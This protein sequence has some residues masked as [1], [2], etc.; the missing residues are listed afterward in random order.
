MLEICR[1]KGLDA[2]QFSCYKCKVPIGVNGQEARLCDYSG[3][4]YCKLCHL[5]QTAVIPARVLHSWDFT[6]RAVCKE[7]MAFLALIN[8]EVKC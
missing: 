7:A 2:Q 5:G 4:Y 3:K 1:D 6:P 8:S